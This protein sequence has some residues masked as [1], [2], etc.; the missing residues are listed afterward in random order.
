MLLDFS[1]NTTLWPAAA[2]QHRVVIVTGSYAVSVD[3][4][5]LTLNRLAAHL[6]R[7]G[8]EVLVLCPAG[9]GQPPVLRHA[10]TMVRVPSVA[11]PIWHEYR[12]TFGLGQ[13]ARSALD[14]FGPTVMHVAVQ[15][16]MG[17]AAQRWAARH[18]VPV[19]CSHHTRWDAYL[20]YYWVK[21]L[22]PALRSA[23]WWGMR[24]FHEGCAATF[25]PS[26]AVAA[27]LRSHGVPRVG[28]WPRGVDHSMFGPEH[29]SEQWRRDALG[30]RAP[31]GGAGG[32]SAGGGSAGGGSAGGGSAGGGI[33]T[34]S[35]KEEEVVVLF[36][37]RLRW[38]KGL[39]DLAAVLAAL[40]RRGVPHR[41][42]VVG[43]GPAR[44]ELRLLL[45]RGGARL[46]GGGRAGAANTSVDD[47]VGE[48]SG[49]GGDG[50]G[51]GDTEDDDADRPS[52]GG[53]GNG[54][55]TLLGRLTGAALATAYA[56][57]DVFLFPSTTEG[58]GATSEQSPSSSA[59]GAM[60]PSGHTWRSPGIV[61]QLRTWRS[62][63]ATH[64]AP[65]E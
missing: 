43:D 4:V 47:G 52:G 31:S 41:A 10:G 64:G 63:R 45:R 56:S 24:R 60:L 61:A 50:H 35:H 48:V 21:P 28:V 27:E 26:E 14:S 25:P 17:H 39:A 20:G 16:A 29:R 55:V 54:A 34:D 65:Q 22:A 51:S 59:H 11:A 1:V 3:G 15:D 38:E 18:G 40:R 2:E 7:R 46:G 33:S 5:A 42:A 19:V 12:L 62:P 53:N 8:H 44:E 57:S 13:A 49:G 9:D 36:V 58:R 32:G 23:M 6:L 37:A 30:V